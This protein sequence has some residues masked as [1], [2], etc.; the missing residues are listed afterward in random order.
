MDWP[1]HITFYPRLH[2][3][4]PAGTG[5]HTEQDNVNLELF[6]DDHTTFT[7][8]SPKYTRRYIQRDSIECIIE[9]QD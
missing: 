2:Q 3:L 5:K 4:I 1:I 9:G 8:V 6:C 7:L